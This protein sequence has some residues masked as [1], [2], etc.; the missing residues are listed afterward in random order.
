MKG[1][2]DITIEG[3]EAEIVLRNLLELLLE[4][5]N[6]VH[7][8]VGEEPAL[9]QIQSE[10]VHKY[11]WQPNR[12]PNVR[13][14]IYCGDELIVGENTNRKKLNRRNHECNTCKQKAKHGR[15]KRS[16]GMDRKRFCYLCAV[17]LGE[18]NCRHIREK[19]R[20]VTNCCDTCNG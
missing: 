9:P 19:R 7:G 10:D 11:N 8:D 14:C 1:N 15:L 4:G 12:P 17:Q 18:E 5:S 2:L 3:D 13:Y 16:L 20:L 6:F